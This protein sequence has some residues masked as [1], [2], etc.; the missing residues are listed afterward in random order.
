MSKSIRPHAGAVTWGQ[1]GEWMKDLEQTMR[2][3]C[4]VVLTAVCNPNGDMVW[5]VTLQSWD[6]KDGHRREGWSTVQ[7]RFPNGRHLSMTALLIQLAHDMERIVTERRENEKRRR[8][9][10]MQLPLP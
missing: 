4:E 6:A 5:Y 10:A 3:R 2:V 8:P 7:G 1:A 9:I